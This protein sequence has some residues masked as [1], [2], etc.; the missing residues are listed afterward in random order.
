[1]SLLLTCSTGEQLPGETSCRAVE[2]FWE[3]WAAWPCRAESKDVIKLF[4]YDDILLVRKLSYDDTNGIFV[5]AF[6]VVVWNVV[7]SIDCARVMEWWSNNWCN[8]QPD[9]IPSNESTQSNV[10]STNNDTTDNQQNNHQDN[11]VPGPS[12]TNVSD[13]VD[14]TN[15]HMDTTTDAF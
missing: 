11:V 1:M 12:N 7:G 8:N 4:L 14:N 2:L 10:Q 5:T 9:N 3:K 13:T 6:V 15:K